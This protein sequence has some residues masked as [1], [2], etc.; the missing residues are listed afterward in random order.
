MAKRKVPTMDA[1]S[2]VI[3]EGLRDTLWGSH[4]ES[5]IQGREKLTQGREGAKRRFYFLCVF[6]P[7]REIKLRKSLHVLLNTIEVF[8]TL[9]PGIA[10][11]LTPGSLGWDIGAASGV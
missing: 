3:H 4:C 7:L 2:G 8:V 1:I 5:Q 6:A 11:M 9:F 10:W